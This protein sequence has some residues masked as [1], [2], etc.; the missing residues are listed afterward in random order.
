MTAGFVS[1]LQ[2]LPPGELEAGLAAFDRSH[3]DP[4]ESIEYTLGFDAVSATRP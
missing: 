4:A 3:P 1:T 2:M